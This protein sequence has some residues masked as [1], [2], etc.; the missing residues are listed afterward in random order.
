MLSGAAWKSGRVTQRAATMQGEHIRMEGTEPPTRSG[1]AAQERI[2]D[3]RRLSKDTHVVPL[4]PAP[5][6]SMP[7]HY[8]DTTL[9][10]PGLGSG[11][12]ISPRRSSSSDGRTSAFKMV[13]NCSSVTRVSSF[14]F[15][16]TQSL[17]TTTLYPRK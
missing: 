9:S 2:S 10:C 7:L 8:S 12:V 16:A 14:V 6:R 4:G 1:E 15:E 11:W 17:G 5:E 13:C 3:A